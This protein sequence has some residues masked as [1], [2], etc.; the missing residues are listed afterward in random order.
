VQI[1]ITGGAGFLGINLARYL[2]QRAGRVTTLDVA[3]FDY[4]DCQGQVR[5]IR[6]DIR[7][8]SVVDHAMQGTDIVVHCAAALPL[9]K[10]EDI[11]STD[12]AGTRNVLEAAQRNSVQRVIHI[13][14]TA[15]YGVPERALHTEETE[16][17][18]DGP[19]AEAKIEAEKLCQE[20]REKGL[21]VPILRPTAFVGPERLGIFALLYDWAKDGRDFPILG[22]GNI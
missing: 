8:P 4:P 15:V 20:F 11:Y 16:L 1:L 7:D 17:K 6:G 12:V 18:P 21:C 3:P 2:L 19:Y 5:S 14:T 9:Y 10:P 13:S 22:R